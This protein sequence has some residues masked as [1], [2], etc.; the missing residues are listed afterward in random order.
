[1]KW[2]NISLKNAHL[3]LK[4]FKLNSGI[5]WSPHFS[6]IVVQKRNNAR[7]FM[8]TGYELLN[9]FVGTVVDDHVVKEPGYKSI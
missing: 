7:F 6:V 8:K 3:L 1:M 2:W 9:P 4:L 5:L